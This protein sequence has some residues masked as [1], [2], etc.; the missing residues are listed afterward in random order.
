MTGTNR[1]KTP[2]Q[3]QADVTNAADQLPDALAVAIAA[4]NQYGHDSDR[5]Q[6]AWET[7]EQ[8]GATIHRQARRLAG[9]SR[10]G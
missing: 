4:T 8:L 6:D 9:K 7:V 10:G 3:R 2:Q 5:A 1:G